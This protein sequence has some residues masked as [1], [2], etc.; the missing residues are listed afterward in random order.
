MKPTVLVMRALRQTCVG[1]MLHDN[2]SNNNNAELS[3][4]DSANGGSNVVGSPLQ[5]YELSNPI[6]FSDEFF[7]S[8]NGELLSPNYFQSLH[9]KI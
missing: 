3:N 1:S 6:K 9:K 4:D 5:S 8:V 2:L 7:R